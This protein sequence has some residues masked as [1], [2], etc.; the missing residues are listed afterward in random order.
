MGFERTQPV[1]GSRERHRPRRRGFASFVR[2]SAATMRRPQWHPARSAVAAMPALMSARRCGNSSGIRLST[3]Q[4]AFF[5]LIE[6]NAEASPRR[7]SSAWAPSAR[8]CRHRRKQPPP[9][10]IAAPRPTPGKQELRV[11]GARRGPV[12]QDFPCG[13]LG[14]G[15]IAAG[16]GC[17]PLLQRQFRR[18]RTG[19]HG[20]AGQRRGRQR[21]RGRSLTRGG[22]RPERSTRRCPRLGTLRPPLRI[23][24][25]RQVVDP[26]AQ[27]VV[28]A[29]DLVLGLVDPAAKLANLFLQRVHPGQ[30]LGHQ[31]VPAGCRRRARQAAGLPDPPPRA[32]WSS[33]PQ[34]LAKLIDFVLQR[35]ALA[36]VHLGH[37]RCQLPAERPPRR[38][39]QR[40]TA[41][42]ASSTVIL[43]HLFTASRGNAAVWVMA[44]GPCLLIMLPA[45]GARYRAAG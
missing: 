9:A 11:I 6:V 10:E 4:A 8:G 2:H 1:H 36:A 12:R 39:G 27:V 43:W 5:S 40:R 28:L 45:D 26:L 16:Q 38:K 13:G 24:L 25:K 30:Q 32:I 18:S 41:C 20:R 35:D 37:R 22:R 33:T 44:P 3:S 21:R 23:N 15:I 34:L 19:G 14:G 7:A 42:R 31:I 29:L 17:I